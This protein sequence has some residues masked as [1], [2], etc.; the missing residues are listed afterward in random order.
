MKLNTIIFFV[1]TKGALSKAAS[2]SKTDGKIKVV[3]KIGRF[4]SFRYPTFN[5]GI[6]QIVIR[7]VM[8]NHAWQI[9][10]TIFVKTRPADYHIILL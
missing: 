8:L 1:D 6:I 10:P 3:S 9:R 7:H 5:P 4:N 2:S